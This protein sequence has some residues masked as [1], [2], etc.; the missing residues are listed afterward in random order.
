VLKNKSENSIRV[1]FPRSGFFEE[2]KVIFQ[3]GNG[4]ARIRFKK[5]GSDSF[6][7]DWLYDRVVPEDHFLR[8]LDAIIPWEQFSD[9]LLQFYGGGAMYGRPPYDPAMMLKTLLIAYLYDLSERAAE[10]QINDSLSMKWF[11][12]LAIDEAAPHHSTVCKFR[13]RLIDND[14]EKALE[15]MLSTIINLAMEQGVE[16]GTIQVID[17]VHTIADVNT[18]KDDKRKKK[19]GK[20]PRDDDAAWGVKHTK[21]KRDGQGKVVKQRQYFYGFKMHASLNTGSELITSL[22]ATAGNAFD[23]H[24][25][26][27][28]L[29]S[30]LEKHIPIG[31]LTADKAYDDSGNHVL[32]ESKGIQSAIILN[33]YRTQKK[34]PNKQVWIRMKESDSYQTGIKER[35]KIERKFGEA[36][37]GHRLARCRYLG[38][39]GYKVQAYMTA[40]A[41]NLKRMV[42]LL[43]GTNFRSRANAYV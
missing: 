6:F 7:G 41:L 32:L 33:D 1:F 20:P 14:K 24:R 30:D 34:D 25:L 4:M 31:I 5:Q 22:I 38:I 15:T 2:E 40:I 36:K 18:Q 3:K 29:D 26:P 23:G 11:L 21:R 9:Q 43:T 8:Q 16:L 37:Q 13:Q 10:Q 17:S 12:G 19:K 27:D 39:D 35:Y 42:K 28:L